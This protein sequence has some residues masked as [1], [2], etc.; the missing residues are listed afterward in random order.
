MEPENFSDVVERRGTRQKG[1]KKSWLK[2]DQSWNG[3]RM[4]SNLE[5]RPNSA[6]M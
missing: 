1:M 2:Y 3:L 5:R 4:S 6:L